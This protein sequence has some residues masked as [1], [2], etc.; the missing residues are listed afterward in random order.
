MLVLL[1]AAAL[2]IA[3]RLFDLQ[4]IHA[5]EYKR[6]AAQALL[7]SP[8]TLP[9]VRGS[10]LDRTGRL[11]VSDEPSWDI[12]IEYRLLAQDEEYLAAY[13]KRLR[14]TG[15]Y[16][17]DLSNQEVEARLREEIA[18]MW[19]LLADFAG[20]PA[21]ELLARAEE[22]RDRVQRIRKVVARH[23]GFDAPVAEERMRH[24]VVGGLDDQQQI[25]AREEF[26][27]Y[28]WVTIEAGTRRV[29][30]AGPP[31]AHIL[32]RTAAVD[33]ERIAEDPYADDKLRRYSGDETWG[34][35]GVEH[36][37][38]G[39]LRG[40]RGH[41]HEDRTGAVLE[42]VA[43]QRGRDV[44]L[45]IRYDL[46]CRLYDLLGSE[47]PRLPHSP[48]GSIVVLDVPSRDVIALVSYPG[49]DPDVFH[50]PEDY[51]RLRADAV[52]MPLR[53]RAVS[54]RYP[55]GSIVKPL[56]CLAGLANG[57]IDLDTR[58]EC[59]GYLF[60]ENPG[61]GASKCW[62]IAGTTRRKAH[63]LINVVQAIEGSCNIFM[64]K[65][66][67][68]L[69]VERLCNFFDIVGLGHDGGTGTGLRE[70]DE[71]INPTPSWLSDV[72]GRPVRRADARLF[73][74]GQGE[75]A[76]TPIQAAN[77]MAVYASGANRRVNLVQ[78]L[79]DDAAWNLPVSDA[80]LNAIHHG[81]YAVVNSPDGTAYRYARFADDR[82]ALCGKTGSATTHPRPVS[83]K[84]T[85][86]TADGRETFTI[87]P[88]GSYV[89]A[90]GTFQRRY[91]EADADSATITIHRRY[92]PAPPAEGGRHADA[93][94]AG[95]LQR[96]GPDHQP[97]Y[98]VPP[99]IAFAVLVEY[100]GSGGRASGPIAQQIAGI[101]IDSLGDELD[102]D[103]AA[104][105]DPFP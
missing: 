13:A 68:A 48:G 100:G 90:K 4:V 3:L 77:L 96:I 56:T 23:R 80:H 75:I 98:D 72:A 39:L 31:M 5:E 47:L 67:M 30:Y 102:P 79:A 18:E 87:L 54:N 104:K 49:Y 7:L 83:Y 37:A 1:L 33:A 35:T 74:I 61:A 10:I 55:P 17:R 19:R 21:E 101:I 86:K 99:R 52:R 59:T 53:F 20:E 93:W 12:K 81:L 73:A 84:V 64:Y 94:F 95:Y 42:D 25:A 57:V 63:G 9:F 40:R 70:E 69:G 50:R 82:Y 29:N 32:G 71:G 60:P 6:Q 65:L 11:L 16:D 91:P 26:G 51:A 45:T 43:P 41:F 38:E 22:I 58:F 103:A 8:E 24:T 89:E 105:T 85:Y 88:A 46:Q 97:L 66:G 62:Q 44:H 27:R 76:V 92:P 36:L 28:P 78:E 15:R 2:L 14:R 34:I